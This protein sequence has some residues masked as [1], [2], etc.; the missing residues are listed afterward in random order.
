VK[1][2]DPATHALLRGDWVGPLRF[3][4]V[5]IAAEFVAELDSGV[6]GLCGHICFVLFLQICRGWLSPGAFEYEV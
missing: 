3:D 2:A 1:R 6:C 4:G 5:A